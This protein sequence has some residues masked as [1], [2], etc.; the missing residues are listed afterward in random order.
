MF[1]FSQLDEIIIRQRTVELNKRLDRLYVLANPGK[2]A[3]GTRFTLAALRG[4]LTRMGAVLEQRDR[5]AAHG[6]A[7]Q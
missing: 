4:W 6:T 2:E 1:N 5:R 7:T 3:S